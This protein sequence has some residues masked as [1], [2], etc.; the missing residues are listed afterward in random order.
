MEFLRYSDFLYESKKLAKQKFLDTGKIN[1]KTFDELAGLDPSNTFKYLPKMI[2]FYLEGLSKEECVSLFTA[3]ED[4]TS[5]NIIKDKDINGYTLERFKSEVQRAS[6]VQTNREIKEI[7]KSNAKIIR[8]DAKVFIVIPFSEDSSVIYG[9]GTK[10]CTA[11]DNDNKF[12]QYRYKNGV[13][14]YY[15]ID[16]TRTVEDKLYKIAVAVYENG[17]MEIFDALNKVVKSSSLNRVLVPLGVSL[18]IFVPYFEEEYDIRK[19]FSKPWTID[20]EGRYSTEGNVEISADML[21][22]DKF[23]ISFGKVGGNFTC[24]YSKLTSLIGSPY[25]V[26]GNFNCSENELTSLEGGPEKVGGNY[27]CA[28]N[29]ITSLKGA[30]KELGGNFYCGFNRLKTLEGGLKRVNS[31]SAKYNEIEYIEN[32]TIQV[33]YDINLKHNPIKMTVEEIKAV[34]GATNVEV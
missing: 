25:E 18:D 24:V 10:W 2:E 8:D 22:N 3:F 33:R 23:P 17:Q 1:N 31:I 26:V 12:N 29:N 30:P 15:I 34:T 7:K 27:F 21:V 19:M 4:Y 28:N 16:R 6:S 11:A 32:G 13:T 9:A 14:L 20:K 5:R